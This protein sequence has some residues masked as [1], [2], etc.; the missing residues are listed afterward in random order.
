MTS[1]FDKMTNAASNTAKG[2]I[3]D[4]TKDL[5]KAAEPATAALDS[6][7]NATKSLVNVEE[8]ATT[9]LDSVMNATKG[10]VNID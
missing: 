4:A 8:A 3:E 9:A 7:I 1:A 10:L 5:I 6:V 2:L